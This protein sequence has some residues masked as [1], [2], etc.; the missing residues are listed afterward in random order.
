MKFKIDEFVCDVLIEVGHDA[1]CLVPDALRS[2]FH[3]IYRIEPYT[4]RHS[5]VYNAVR[6]ELERQHSA[7][8]IMLYGGS[9]VAALNQACENSQNKLVTISLINRA[10]N[11][12]LANAA[13]GQHELVEQIQV[14]RHWFNDNIFHPLVIVNG[15]G[16]DRGGLPTSKVMDALLDV[17]PHYYFRVLDDDFR[18]NVLVA[19]P[20]AWFHA[21][22]TGGTVPLSGGQKATILSSQD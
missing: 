6:A 18:R 3:E 1:M 14:I 13:D 2:G 11:Y 17:C 7:T 16:V 4:A 20:P 9:A 22:A 21:C 15:V 12:G 5:D 8:K 10:E 19:V